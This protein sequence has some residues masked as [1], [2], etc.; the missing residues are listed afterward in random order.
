MDPSKK[1]PVR[2][3]AVQFRF[4]PS[5]AEA[6]IRRFQVF[7]LKHAQAE[8]QAAPAQIVEFDVSAA[9]PVRVNDAAG[10]VLL[11]IP[12]RFNQCNIWADIAHLPETSTALRSLNDP[13]DQTVKSSIV[14]ALLAA[15]RSS[16]SLTDAVVPWLAGLKTYLEDI[17]CARLLRESGALHELA[18]ALLSGIITSESAKSALTD[19]VVSAAHADGP[20]SVELYQSKS[21]TFIMTPFT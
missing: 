14:R 2:A 4:S 7:G 12:D 15:L 8:E 11:R 5:G 10:R 9:S 13:Q 1:K 19:V 21:E 18:P 20:T 3:L 6:R 17:S 16:G